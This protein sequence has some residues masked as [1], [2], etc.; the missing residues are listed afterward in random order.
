MIF[1]KA[2]SQKFRRVVNKLLIFPPFLKKKETVFFLDVFRGQRKGALGTNGLR[3]LLLRVNDY[4][5]Q[6]YYML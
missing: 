2:A 1:R 6:L 4:S 3:L 5:F